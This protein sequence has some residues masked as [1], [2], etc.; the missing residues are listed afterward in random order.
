MS[1]LLKKMMARAGMTKIPLFAREALGARSIVQYSNEFRRIEG[2]PRRTWETDPSLATITELL[3]ALLKT[4]QGSMHL[5]PIQA[6]ALHDACAHGGAFLPVGVGQG[7]ALISLLVAVVMEAQRPVL[8]VPADLRDQTNQ[9]VVPRMLEHWRL[10]KNLKIVGYS[11]LSLEKNKDLLARLNPDL[12]ILDECHK[13]KNKNAGRTRRMVRWF[14]EHPETKC[15]AMSGTVSKRSLKDFAHIVEWCLKS[16]A[17]VPSQWNE[18]SQWADALDENVPDGQR[19]DPGVLMRLCEGDENARQGFRRR[20]TETPGVVA[21]K[22]SDL[23]VSLVI[24]PHR[25]ELP[26]D[27]ARVI[28]KMTATWETP[29]GDIISEAPELW[30]HTREIS[31]GFCYRWDPM[32]PKEWM[33][34]RREWKAFVREKIRH[35][36]GKYDT[37]L[38]VWIA[39]KHEDVARKWALV[40]N[41]FRPNTV[42]D[43]LSDFALKSCSDWLRDGGICWVEHVEFGKRLESF[44]GVRYFGAGDSGILNSKDKSIIASVLAHGT[45]KNLER[46]SRNLF[47]SCP[48]SGETF[49]QVL[50]RT[51]RSGQQ[52]D[53]VLNEIFLH[54][55]V[56]LAA[57]DKS[58]NDARYIEDTLGNRQ[59]LNYAVILA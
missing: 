1:E 52:A 55:D 43:W 51:H 53:E 47:T 14:R 54:T 33:S 28:T 24:Q 6:V 44:S 16:R 19:A 31:L 30:R 38:Q 3:T 10:P 39:C 34:A 49:E 40:K 15:V 32:P 9:Y 41:T 58:K 11:E 8:F 27:L 21:S 45:G 18:L 50:G 23:G 12:I 4:P 13:L 37:E 17:P 35:S 25:V 7:K 46:F 5:W 22:A 56:A 26:Q 57:F 2:L 59:K 29:S 20:L 42:A 36:M 48:A